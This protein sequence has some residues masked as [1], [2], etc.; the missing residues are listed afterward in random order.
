MATPKKIPEHVRRA[1]R[2]ALET[3]QE[4]AET[5][6]RPDRIDAIAH[7]NGDPLGNEIEGRSQFR[8]TEVRD[9][10][11]AMLPTLMKMFFGGEHGVEYVPQT[12]EDV[13]DAGEANLYVNQIVLGEDNPGFLLFY[14]WLTDAFMTRLGIMKVGSTV[15]RTPQKRLLPIPPDPK[16]GGDEQVVMD[17][18]AGIAAMGEDAAIVEFN[19]TRDGEVIAISAV[20]ESKKVT[21]D[22]VMPQNFI[23]EPAARTVMDAK[24]IGDVSFPTRSDLLAMGLPKQAVMDA[25][26]DDQRIDEEQERWLR[27][28][29][30]SGVMESPVLQK[31]A[32]RVRFTEAYLFLSMKEDDLDAQWYRVRTLGDA[33]DIADME[34]C[35]GHPYAVFCPNPQPHRVE[36]LSVADD[37]KDIQDVNTK[38]TRAMLDALAESI[39]PRTEAVEGQVNMRDLLDRRLG[40]VVR[41]RAPG[42]LREI[43]RPN[44]G[45]AAFPILEHFNAIKE[46]RTGTTR[47]AIGLDPDSLQSST[48]QAVE[49]TMSK[50]AERTELI[51]HLFAETALKPLFSRILYEITSGGYSRRMVKFGAR[52]LREVDPSRWNPEMSVVPKTALGVGAKETRI[53]ALTG[54]AAKQELVLTTVG[55]MNPLVSLAQ[56]A[57]TLRELAKLSGYVDAERFFSAVAPDYQPPQPETPPNVEMEFLKLEAKKAE[58]EDQRKQNELQVKVAELQAKLAEKEREQAMKQQEILLRDDRE[59]DAKAN[60]VMLKLVELE[61]KYADLNAQVALQLAQQLRDDTMDD[62][63]ASET[64]PTNA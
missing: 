1:V 40:G 2:S 25:Q 20:K 49:G 21:L 31:S 6:R 7:Y 53:A 62:D 59:R 18:V 15:V 33:F 44:A 57:E 43:V 26:A 41:V 23:Y 13:E 63:A 30:E 16:L 14:T 51:A 34:E 38:V 60:D 24:V 58:L 3:A 54:I 10:I 45:E 42:M 12:S 8:T 35:H 27:N 9:T 4:F 22:L 19:V 17:N 50:A 11:M 47:A 32:E 28:P 64:P 39:V 5:T 55:M 48:R 56:Y 37:T 29:N 36:G 46:N 61:Q 52:Q